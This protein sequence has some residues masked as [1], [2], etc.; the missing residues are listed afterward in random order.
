MYI[1][2]FLLRCRL[3]QVP[4]VGFTTIHK[5]PRAM[6]LIYTTSHESATCDDA[7]DTTIHELLLVMMLTYTN[8]HDCFLWWCLKKKQDRNWCLWWCSNLA[9]YIKSYTSRCCKSRHKTDI[10]MM[11]LWTSSSCM[12][13]YRL[14]C[15]I[16]RGYINCYLWWRHVHHNTWNAIVLDTPKCVSC[17]L[18]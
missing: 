4:L 1:N 5:L 12:K 18:W 10:A 3:L 6:N 14:W 2:Q 11:M 8:M 17:Y 9:Q 7:Q 15:T 16:T 13:C